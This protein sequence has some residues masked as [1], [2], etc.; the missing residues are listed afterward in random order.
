MKVDDLGVPPFQETSIWGFH[1]V[2]VPKMDEVETPDIY[3]DLWF[4]HV[5]PVLVND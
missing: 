3:D 5:F 4:I 1:K 2:G